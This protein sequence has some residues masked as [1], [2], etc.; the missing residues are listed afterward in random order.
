VD[1]TWAT[2]AHTFTR[3]TRTAFR[4]SRMVADTVHATPNHHTMVVAKEGG[5]YPYQPDHRFCTRVLHLCRALSNT[6][7]CLDYRISFADTALSF[8]LISALRVAAAAPAATATLATTLGSIS[9][10]LPIEPTRLSACHSLSEPERA[11]EPFLYLPVSFYITQHYFEVA[12][13]YTIATQHKTTTQYGTNHIYGC[14][15][16]D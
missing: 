16:A 9:I 11:A 5:R 1:A 3:P 10:R 6:L 15:N 14:N 7:L 4:K 13:F 8:A 2:F 12:C